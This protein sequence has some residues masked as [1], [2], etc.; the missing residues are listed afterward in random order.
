[1]RIARQS[2]EE[3]RETAD[4]VE[5]AS[6]FTALRR[7]GTRF[8]GLC[9]YPDHQEKTP[10]FSVSP[11]KGFYYCFGCSRGGDAIKLVEDLK[12]LPFA[13]A[14]AHL[15]ERYNIELRFEGGAPPEKTSRRREIHKA[16]AA[17]AVYY[18]R[19]L[20]RSKSQ[21]AERARRYLL[22]R[23]LNVSTIGEFRVGL[24]PSGGG[25]VG[26]AA[27]LGFGRGVLEAAG[28]LSRGG[29]ERFSGRI[30]FPISDRRGRIA[31]FG[32]R[33][34]GEGGPKY[35]NSPETEVFDKRNLLYGFPQVM[36][37]MRRERVALVVEGYTDVL[38]LY[39]SGVR[40]AVATL[41]TSITASHLRLLSGYADEIY[42]LFDP[43]AAGEKAVER[44]AAA[45][46]E[47]KLGL[48]VLRLPE[49]PADW[50]RGH[51]GEEFLELLP[52]AESALSYVLRRKAER[53]RLADTAERARALEEV[54]AL[55]QKIED[56]VFRHD[57][58]RLASEALGV[59]P[60]VLVPDR[61]RGEE[62]RRSVS[63]AELRD[64]HEEAGRD[65]LALMLVRQD[66]VSDFLREGFPVAGLDAPLRFDAEDFATARQARLFE[67]LQ[68][69]VGIAVDHLLSDEEL[70]PFADLLAALVETGER[71]RPSTTAAREICLRLAILSRQRRKRQTT[72]ISR[73]EALQSEI[74]LLREAQ[75]TLASREA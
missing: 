32:A 15:A 60:H 64:P 3:L 8:V 7:Q 23:G 19:V 9:P 52:G 31:G 25:F 69:R 48:K 70:R 54:R 63:T 55:L 29:R 21:E 26:T 16:L 56:P 73:K 65:V 57:A 1:M 44:A 30:T 51:T 13:E 58:Q 27:R 17:A 36:E 22:G 50:L 34:L 45:A 6:E 20:M 59:A 66:L 75:R 4:I 42:I 61:G 68:H 43:D 41:G 72:D 67:L 12:S 47:L 74:R 40:N 11:E 14:V 46:A 49:D 35:L 62:R 10:S 38:M 28:L 18:H 33:V 5:V 39:Q 71:L 24:A 2:I 53:V 37:A